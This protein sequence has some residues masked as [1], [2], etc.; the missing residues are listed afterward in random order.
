MSD[1][2]N[3]AQWETAIDLLR[4]IAERLDRGATSVPDIATQAAFLSQAVGPA[5]ATNLTILASADAFA[6][7]L[8]SSVQHSRDDNVVHMSALATGAGNLLSLGR[9]ERVVTPNAQSTTIASSPPPGAPVV[10]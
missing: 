1:L 9:R 5:F 10:T 2:P 7:T 3:Q 6:K 8:L 4:Q